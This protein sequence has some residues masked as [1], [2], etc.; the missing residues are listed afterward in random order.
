MSKINI[1]TI[2]AVI[3]VLAL[4]AFTSSIIVLQFA[5]TSGIAHIITSIVS[6]TGS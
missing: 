6:P 4:L 2:I 1:Q 5:P 3:V